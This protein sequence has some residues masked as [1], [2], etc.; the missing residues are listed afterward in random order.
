MVPVEIIDWNEGYIVHP[1]I[2]PPTPI[3]ALEPLEADCVTD[4]KNLE[5]MQFTGLKDKNGKEIYEGDIVNFEDS[6]DK[7][8][9]VI[10]VVGGWMPSDAEYEAWPPEEEIEVV[11]NIHEN[12]T[13]T[14]DSPDGEEG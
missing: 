1:D 6:Y 9:E 10:P 3:D 2:A 4:L 14:S 8:Y 11:G 13:L 5:L 12:P 7:P